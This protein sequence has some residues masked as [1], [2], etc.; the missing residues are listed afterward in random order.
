MKAFEASEMRLKFGETIKG[1]LCET[2]QLCVLI[3]PLLQGD[4]LIGGGKGGGDIRTGKSRGFSK[5]FL[6]R[7]VKSALEG[8]DGRGGYNKSGE[9]VPIPYDSY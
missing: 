9:P 2:Q 6:P 1:V 8:I 7:R 4:C 5:Q 3:S